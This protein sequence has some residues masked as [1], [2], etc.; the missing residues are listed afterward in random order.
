VTQ[1]AEVAVKS[2]VRK[3]PLPDLTDM[4]SVSVTAPRNIISRNPNA[5]FFV[6]SKW[7]FFNLI[8]FLSNLLSN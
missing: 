6:V 8:N 3:S 5:I 7:G 1:V 4:G 2:D